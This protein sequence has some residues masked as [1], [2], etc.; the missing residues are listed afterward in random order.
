MNI[1]ERFFGHTTQE[2]NKSKRWEIFL[3]CIML[4]FMY[5]MARYAPQMV[6]NKESG[7]GERVVVIDA[8][9]GGV[10]PGKVAINRALEK[11]II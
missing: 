2:D 4:F 7:K 9:H 11:D 8:G 6:D 3:A 1:L 10:D 5:M